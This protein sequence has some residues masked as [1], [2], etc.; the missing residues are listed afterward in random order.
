[1][2]AD[3]ES[4]LIPYEESSN[5]RIYYVL[6]SEF[7]LQIHLI[8][9]AATASWLPA[10]LFTYLSARLVCLPAGFMPPVFLEW[11]KKLGKVYLHFLLPT[12]DISTDEGTDIFWQTSAL[13]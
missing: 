6:N 3:R 10:C 4:F 11:K 1:M 8:L 5:Y 9:A 7:E 12:N 2:L 13:I